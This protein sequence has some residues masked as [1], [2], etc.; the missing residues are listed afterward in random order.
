MTTN[1]LTQLPG[2]GGQLSPQAPSGAIR[3]LLP[4][5][6]SRVLHRNQSAIAK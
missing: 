2:G 1:E 6:Q 5:K 3:P 4:T